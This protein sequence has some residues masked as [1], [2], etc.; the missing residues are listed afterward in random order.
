TGR[1]RFGWRD[2]DP[3]TGR[4]TAKD[5]IGAAGGDS[6]WYGYCSDDPVNGRDPQ[7]LYECKDNSEKCGDK[8]IYCNHNTCTEN[9]FLCGDYEPITKDDVNMIR[10]FP[11]VETLFEWPWR[12]KKDAGEDKK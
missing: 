4:F 2:Y 12:N 3:D 5:P 8:N 1:V 11:G 10:S 7:G 9:C 6:D